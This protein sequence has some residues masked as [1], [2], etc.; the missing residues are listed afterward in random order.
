MEAS[1]PTVVRI[2]EIMTSAGQG[3]HTSHP[4]R[5]SRGFALFGGQVYGPEVGATRGWQGGHN[6]RHG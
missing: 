5:K 2:Q 6:L 3:L 1:M 4:A